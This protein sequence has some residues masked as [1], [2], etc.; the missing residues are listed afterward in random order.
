[1]LLGRFHG[2]LRINRYIVIFEQKRMN[3]FNNKISNILVIKSLESDP[4]PT[5]S[6]GRASEKFKN[7]SRP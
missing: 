7:L 3:F 4:A 6:G 2:D 5:F 1:M